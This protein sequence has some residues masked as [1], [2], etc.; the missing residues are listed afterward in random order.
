MA[1]RVPGGGVT[2]NPFGPTWVRGEGEPQSVGDQVQDNL[3][4]QGRPKPI[5]VDD[6][7]CD[8]LMARL[9]A[10]RKKLARLLGDE[11]DDYDLR[12]AEGTIA[13]IDKH[14]IVYVG[15]DFLLEEAD[16][17]DLQ[18]GVLAHEIG[19]RPQRWA[20]YRGEQPRTPQEVTDLCRLE[21][22]RA[23]WFSGYAL[24]EL[25]LKPDPLCAFLHRVQTQ[26]HPEYFSAALREKTIREAFKVGQRRSKDVAKFFPEFARMRSARGD[27]G[28]G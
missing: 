2:K 24:A 18:V 20:E 27:L 6:P 22:T 26:P 28:E 16:H 25:G 10:Y 15:R 21:E 11:P 14:G 5:E 12:L 1:T 3:F 13:C 17:L 23:D 9:H 19:H 8:R 7:T 4:G